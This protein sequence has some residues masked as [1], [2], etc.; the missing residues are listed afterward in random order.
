M[1]AVA[2]VTLLAPGAVALQ[3]ASAATVRVPV[4]A[5]PE[6]QVLFRAT[7]PATSS[8]IVCAWYADIPSVLRGVMIGTGSV[9]C[10]GKV[11]SM[12]TD[13]TLFRNGRIGGGSI[14]SCHDCAVIVDS[15]SYTCKYP[16]SYNYWYTAMY[17]TVVFPPGYIPHSI[18]KNP[19]SI[20][21]R[22]YC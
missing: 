17:A 9:V 4:Q 2:A 10:S 8:G 15:A 13:T 12:A 20:Q 14:G 19:A 22:V 18:S 6:P 3:S 5:A 11:A 21:V 16:Y 7:N 1:S